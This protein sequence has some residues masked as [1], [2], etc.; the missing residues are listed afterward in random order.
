MPRDRARQ[1]LQSV[2]HASPPHQSSGFLARSHFDQRGAQPTKTSTHKDQRSRKHSSSMSPKRGSQSHTK[3]RER[4][5]VGRQGQ[6]RVVD[7]RGG[8]RLWRRRHQRSILSRERSPSGILPSY[9]A[10]LGADTEKARANARDPNNG[11]LETVARG[12]RCRRHRRRRRSSVVVRRGSVLVVVCRRRLD[13][14]VPQ[15]RPQ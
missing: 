8:Y 7:S 2:P 14:Q 9:Y 6:G 4:E 10:D 11:V 15:N 13:G 1:H 3:E 5:R 12:R